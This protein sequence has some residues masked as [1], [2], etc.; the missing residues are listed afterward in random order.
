MCHVIDAVSASFQSF[1]HSTCFIEF[2]LG[3]GC[4]DSFKWYSCLLF[5]LLLLLD[6]DI[7]VNLLFE[8]IIHTQYW[9][10][11]RCQI[12]LFFLRQRLSPASFEYSKNYSLTEL[13]WARVCLIGVWSSE[14]ETWRERDKKKRLNVTKRPIR[15]YTLA[16]LGMNNKYNVDFCNWIKYSAFYINHCTHCNR[17]RHILFRAHFQVNKKHFM[18][19]RK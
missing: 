15:S 4:W 13:Y 19:I 14:H 10:Q 12:H 3:A 16:W 18:T 9:T 1:R 7:T 8:W 6:D 11:K 17:C 5:L 2:G